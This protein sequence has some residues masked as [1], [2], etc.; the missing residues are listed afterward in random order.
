MTRLLKLGLPVKNLKVSK[1]VDIAEFAEAIE[2]EK[3]PAFE[4]WDMIID[5]SIL[6]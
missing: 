3:K 4:W 2:L 5:I 6:G 1:P